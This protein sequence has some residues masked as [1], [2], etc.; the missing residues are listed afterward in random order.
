MELHLLGLALFNHF[1]FAM[2]LLR[3]NYALEIDEGVSTR[4]NIIIHKL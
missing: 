2:I 3:L 4:T 1:Y